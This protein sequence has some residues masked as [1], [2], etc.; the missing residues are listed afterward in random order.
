MMRH[1]I[2]GLLALLIFVG[3]VVAASFPPMRDR[4]FLFP[5]EKMD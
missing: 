2:N 1:L 5:D 4:R 3:P